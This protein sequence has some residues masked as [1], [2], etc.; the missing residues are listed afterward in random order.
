M[1]TVQSAEIISQ[2]QLRYGAGSTCWPVILYKDNTLRPLCLTFEVNGK[3]QTNR[4]MN[5]RFFK[6]GLLPE[7]FIDYLQKP[8]EIVPLSGH[9][10]PNP[11]GQEIINPR[12]SST[13][14]WVM[15]LRNRGL[16]TIDI[17]YVWRTSAGQYFGLELSTFYVPMN[18]V[19][20]ARRLVGHFIAKRTAAPHAHQFRILAEVAN[21]QNMQLNLV[22]A[23]ETGRGSNQLNTAGNVFVIPIDRGVAAE[24]HA[25]KF[26]INYKFLSYKEWLSSL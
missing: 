14:N 20:D 12:F 17:D 4:G 3:N 11:P 1:T 13:Y 7:F 25:G 6:Q 18:T 8:R 2:L 21:L 15:N 24:L 5:G 19:Q 23:N 16:N 26:P 9:E 10:W 22:F